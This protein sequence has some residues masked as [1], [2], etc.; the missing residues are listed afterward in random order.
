MMV[1]LVPK[2][3]FADIVGSEEVTSHNLISTTY[4]ITGNFLLSQI[5]K[6]TVDLPRKW[7]E[8]SDNQ[9]LYPPRVMIALQRSSENMKYTIS[10]HNEITE[11]CTF[12]LV[13][14]KLVTVEAKGWSYSHASPV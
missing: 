6:V 8:Y 13:S 1:Y 11:E 10:I 12:T 2:D 9:D 5:P 7:P 3:S 4:Y 14:P